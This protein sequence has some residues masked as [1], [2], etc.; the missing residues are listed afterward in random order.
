MRKLFFLLTTLTILCGFACQEKKSTTS[1]ENTTW[2]LKL[3]TTE[4]TTQA[5]PADVVI[6]ATF[7][8]GKL[9]GN[10]G[11]N[12]YS[13][14]Y[15]LIGTRLSLGPVMSTKMSCPANMVESRY[16]STLRGDMVWKVNGN[17]LTIEGPGVVLVYE[18]P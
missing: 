10:G 9:A 16:F 17:K 15:T 6:T 12:S 14:T 7:K 3:L 4:G 11:C 1:F 5:V 2:Q 8:D 18:K 13:A